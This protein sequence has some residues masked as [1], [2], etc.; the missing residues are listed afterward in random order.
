MITEGTQLWRTLFSRLWRSIN[1]QSSAKSSSA[2][3]CYSRSQFSCQSVGNSAVS[4]SSLSSSRSK[5]SDKSPWSVCA[6]DSHDT[7]T[8]YEGTF[9][10][11]SLGFG[12]RSRFNSQS[13]DRMLMVVFALSTQSC[14][15]NLQLKSMSGQG[16]MASPVS[17][18]PTSSPPS[19]P[20]LM[21]LTT[22]PATR[23]LCQVHSHLSPHYRPE[24]TLTLVNL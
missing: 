23:S 7:A 15:S 20:F 10:I 21:P 19:A 5:M 17:T 1:R 16:S 22:L 14:A 2:Q 3:K 11:T 18:N 13:L 9:F 6:F 12:P 8:W 24:N 4:C